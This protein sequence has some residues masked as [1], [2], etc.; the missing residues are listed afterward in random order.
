MAAPYLVV[1]GSFG[2]VGRCESSYSY[3]FGLDLD[4]L[5]L[6]KLTNMICV[7]C[8]NKGHNVFQVIQLSDKSIVL[9]SFC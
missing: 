7:N 3:G 1:T 4:H 9:I 8:H 6:D 5:F 2:S